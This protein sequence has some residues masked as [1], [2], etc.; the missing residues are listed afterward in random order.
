MDGLTL[1]TQLA[2]LGAAFCG[3]LVSGLSG[4]AMGLVVSGVWLHIIAPDQNALLIVL[5]GLM[6]QG[7]GIWRVRHAV[8]W[9]K[10]APFIIGGAIGVPIGTALLT[11]LDATKFRFGMGVLLV[12]YSLYSLMRPMLKVAHSIVSMD[13]GV[14][15]ANGLI[16]GLT[17]L[18]GIAVTI[19]CQ[20]RGGPK[21]TQRAIFQPVLFST[22]VMTAVSLAVAGTFTAE[23]I[24]L[25]AFAL[26]VLI[27]GLWCGI[28]LYGK[29]DD[30]SF[31]KVILLLLLASG[32]SLVVPASIFR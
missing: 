19:W 23:A 18:G 14:G 25:Y 27:V 29:L 1:I 24:K 31:R 13:V 26:P 28:R 7:S 10:V 17:G 9:R 16:G 21:D 6:T 4:F 30:A 5:C 15:I 22:F 20:L 12:L 8:V 11:T 3:G 2:F 32:V